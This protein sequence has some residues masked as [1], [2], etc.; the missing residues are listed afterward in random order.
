[1]SLEAHL[2]AVEQRTEDALARFLLLVLAGGAD[3]S[4][5]VTLTRDQIGSLTEMTPIEIDRAFAQLRKRRLLTGGTYGGAP[6]RL[7]LW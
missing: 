2:W 5:F 4:G 1:M 6:V 7:A 3:G